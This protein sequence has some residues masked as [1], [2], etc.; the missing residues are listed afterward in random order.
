[1]RINRESEQPKVRD[2]SYRGKARTQITMD[3]FSIIPGLRHAR[4]TLQS[5]DIPAIEF[6]RQAILNYCNLVKGLGNHIR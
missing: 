6:L 1:M 4:D 3:R 2:N 5:I